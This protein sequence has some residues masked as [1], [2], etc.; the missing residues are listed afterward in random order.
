MTI[1]NHIL[2]S[3]FLILPLTLSVLLLSSCG[4]K[5]INSNE[6]D[7]EE[8]PIVDVAVVNEVPVPQ[9]EQYTANVEAFNT[10]NISPSTMN[11]IKSINV[12]VGDKVSKGQVLVVL[13]DAAL[14]QLQLNLQQLE[15]DYNLAVD[16]LHIG[17]GTQTNV[18]KLKSQ[19]D[20]TRTQYNNLKENTILTSPV[21]GVV[22]ARNYDP[23]D[24][25][26][27]Q[28]VLT[29]GQINPSVK[30][31]INIT[32]NDLS[33]VKNGMPV[34]VSFDALPEEVFEGK[35]SRIYPNINTS[36]RTFQAEVQV[37]NKNSLLF[38]GMFARVALD[39]GTLN[40]VVV[41]D[42][43]VVKQTGS[44]NRYVYVY[45]N[46]TVSFNKVSLGR[47][48]ENGYVILDGVNDG[49]TVV[50]AGQTK[51]ADGVSVKLK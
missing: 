11:R 38:P 49:D 13:D 31:I 1:N 19:L 12:E 33:K 44:G 9:T 23:G 27:A 37:D 2:P 14:N 50:I 34:V 30:I 51:L 35:I 16:L 25:T 45:H 4:N 7:T 42:R 3:A 20:A 43:A 15:R 40:Q 17:S 28:P 41:P 47:Q 5:K 8:L 10:N 24:M 29:V 18:D 21:T 22:T 6:L 26:G 48:T 32:E 36:T 46:G 39:R